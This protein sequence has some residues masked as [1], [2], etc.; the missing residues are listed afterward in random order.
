MKANKI[1]P[2]KNWWF[3]SF[4][5]PGVHPIQFMFSEQLPKSM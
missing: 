2:K 3:D 4:K 1:H 5:E